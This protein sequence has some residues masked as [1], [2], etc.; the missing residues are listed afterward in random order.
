M[1]RYHLRKEYYQIALKTIFAKQQK[2]SWSIV[3]DQVIKEQN[4]PQ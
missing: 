3:M 1:K 4:Q 2:Y